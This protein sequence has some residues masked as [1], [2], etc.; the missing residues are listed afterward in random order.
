MESNASGVFACGDAAEWRNR[1]Y[2]VV[3]AAREQAVVA[4]SNMVNPGSVRYG[5]TIPSVR[6]KVGSCA[7][8]ILSPKVVPIRRLITPTRKKARR[9]EQWYWVKKPQVEVLVKSKVAA[10]SIIDEL[11]KACTRTQRS[12]EGHYPGRLVKLVREP[13]FG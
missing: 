2:G 7:S 13:E 12:I 11:L 8:A 6:L 5:G 3:P 4:A 1:I 9:S 10:T